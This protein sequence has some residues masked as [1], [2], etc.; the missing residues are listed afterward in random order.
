MPKR[1]ICAHYDG[2]PSLRP[3]THPPLFVPEGFFDNN[4]KVRYGFDDYVSGYVNV[5]PDAKKYS[6][7]DNNTG[8]DIKKQI[9]ELP[10]FWQDRISE[11]KKNE[12]K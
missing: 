2:Q 7:E 4:V 6:F 8:T 5:N 3:E 11:V 9:E 1:E 12:S 10:L